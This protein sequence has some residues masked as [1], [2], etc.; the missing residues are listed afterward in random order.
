MNKY[1]RV[2]YDVKQNPVVM[3]EIFEN[4]A[5]L[6]STKLTKQKLYTTFTL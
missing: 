1:V 5:G 4:I 3:Q 2:L 6:I